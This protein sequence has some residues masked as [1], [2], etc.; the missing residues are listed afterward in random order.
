MAALRR[1]AL[2]ER[3]LYQGEWLAARKRG[4]LH[5]LDLATSRDCAEKIYVQHRLREHGAELWRWL[6]GGASLYVC[7]DATRMAPDVHAA[8]REVVATH[9]ARSADAAEEYLR[10][11]AADRRYLRTY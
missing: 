1:A 5:R 3:F 7:G 4:L 9:G 6:E 2:L 8:L 11:L 10:D